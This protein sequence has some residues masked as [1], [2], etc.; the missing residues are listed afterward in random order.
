MYNL[1]R[2]FTIRAR[3]LREVAKRSRA[4]EL[5]DCLAQIER[6]FEG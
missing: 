2:L 5:E 4:R 3:R 6:G 1:R